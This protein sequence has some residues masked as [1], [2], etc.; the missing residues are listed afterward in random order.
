MNDKLKQIFGVDKP[1]IGMVHLLALPGNFGYEGDLEKVINRALE[2]AAALKRGG[3]HGYLI[4]N[5]GSIPFHI[6][7]G[8]D[9]MEVA[10]M[11]RIACTLREKVD[12]PFG[13]NIASNGVRQAL[14]VAK[15]AGGQFVRATGWVNGYYSPSG[16]VAP[17][18]AACMEYKKK[19]NA[20]NICVFA[21]IKVKNGS[22]SFIQ[23][24]TLEEMGKDA[25][26]ALA[27]GVILTGA[28]TGIRPDPEEL[29]RMKK[30]V[31][32]PVII[33]SGTTK[34]NLEELLPCGDA[35]IIGTYFKANGRMSEP[36]CEEKVRDFM[37]AW[38]ALAKK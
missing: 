34:D 6:G 32:G 21:D 30:A 15:A 28:S 19:I 8:I 2:D 35:F 22:H 31:K 36:V 12:L 33:G 7:E 10:A 26:S 37:K 4:E 20:E 9:V 29:R 16:F 1:V 5:A 27:D 3:A 17:C 25:L 38:E 18:A 14:A 13:I 23:D 24:K 11:S